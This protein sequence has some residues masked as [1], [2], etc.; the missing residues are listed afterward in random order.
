MDEEIEAGKWNDLPAQQRKGRKAGRKNT[1]A[2]SQPLP[3]AAPGSCLPARAELRPPSPCWLQNQELRA[4]R[5]LLNSGSSRS[6][7]AE[8]PSHGAEALCSDY[9]EKGF[10]KQPLHKGYLL[11]HQPNTG[12]GTCRQQLLLCVI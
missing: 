7:R 3:R 11:L 9:M 10:S 6:P 12:L 4:S 2:V 1:G 5:A 8:S